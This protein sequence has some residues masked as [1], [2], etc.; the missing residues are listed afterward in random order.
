MNRFLRSEVKNLVKLPEIVS[1]S[2][3][4]LQS[5][6]EH[7]VFTNII[8]GDGSSSEAHSFFEMRSR[9]FGYGIFLV[10]L[11]KNQKKKKRTT[12]VWHSENHFEAMGLTKW[13]SYLEDSVLDKMKKQIRHYYT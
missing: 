11:Q 5:L 8:I 10:H 12:Y 13:M 3:R 4:L 6:R 2:P 7:F 1:E 9:D